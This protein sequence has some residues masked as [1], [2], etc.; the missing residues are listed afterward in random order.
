MQAT[1]FIQL[2]A[3]QNDLFA[4]DDGGGAWRKLAGVMPELVACCGIQRLYVVVVAVDEDDPI[5]YERRCFVRPR[6]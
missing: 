6:R 2:C 4:L 5:V 1:K 3:S